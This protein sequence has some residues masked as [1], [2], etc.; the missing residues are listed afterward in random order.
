MNQRRLTQKEK[1]LIA[2]GAAI[3]AGCIKCSN[4]HFTQAFEQG[5]TTEEVQRAVTDATLVIVSS[6]EIL[7]R[8]AYNLIKVARKEQPTNNTESTESLSTLVKIAAAVAAS[9]TTNIKKYVELAQAD[10]ISSGEISLA[11][12]MARAILNK[13]IEFADEAITETKKD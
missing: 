12:K 13:A 1:E 8:H 11:I 6:Y 5:A 9:S 2:V 10:G 7:Q 4:Y 3:S